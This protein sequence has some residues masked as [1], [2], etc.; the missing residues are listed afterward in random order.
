M[1]RTIYTHDAAMLEG[2]TLTIDTRTWSQGMY[3]ITGA[4]ATGHFT[5]KLMKE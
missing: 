3:L 5:Q 2:S 1:G 4:N